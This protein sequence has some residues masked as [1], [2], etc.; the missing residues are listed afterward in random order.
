MQ[1]SEGPGLSSRTVDDEASL[2]PCPKKQMADLIF[3][4]IWDVATG[5]SLARLI[6]HAQ[7]GGSLSFSP[8][9]R[10]IAIA[11]ANGTLRLAVIPPIDPFDLIDYARKKL[12]VGRMELTGEELEGATKLLN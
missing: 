4:Q 7:L 10:S 3:V 1:E 9:G 11:M 2:Q 5:E 8:D 12:P 6:G